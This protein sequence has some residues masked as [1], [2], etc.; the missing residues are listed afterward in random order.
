MAEGYPPMGADPC[1]TALNGR[2]A[3]QNRM[4]SSLG[5]PV[6]VDR[7]ISFEADMLHDV[8][9]AEA[10]R[11]PLGEISQLQPRRHREDRRLYNERV[12]I[13]IEQRLP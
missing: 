9:A 2:T 13:A 6:S 5:A 11:C 7:H 4:P 12:F 3:K 1:Y 10:L 8:A